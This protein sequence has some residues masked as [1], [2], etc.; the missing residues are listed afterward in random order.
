MHDISLQEPTDP[1]SHGLNAIDLISEHTEVENCLAR[2]TKVL[3]K[4]S[5]QV[6]FQ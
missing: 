3:Q 4:H 2:L 5:S 6:P 1:S